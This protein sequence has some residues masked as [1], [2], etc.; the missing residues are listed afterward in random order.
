MFLAL[1][2][3]YPLTSKIETGQKLLFYI[4]GSADC[5]IKYGIAKVS[6]L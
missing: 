5:K 3:K 1:A 6:R 4:C 2:F